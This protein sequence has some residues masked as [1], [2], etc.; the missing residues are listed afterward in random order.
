MDFFFSQKGIG[1]L[2]MLLVVFYGVMLIASVH[3]VNGIVSYFKDR[4]DQPI[5][6]FV[7]KVEQVQEAS[8]SA[9]IEPTPE[10]TVEPQKQPEVLAATTI[11]GSFDVGVIGKI[12]EYRVA[13]GLNT[14]NATPKLNQTAQ[15]RINYLIDT[16]TWSHANFGKCFVANGVRKHY[17]ENLARQWDNSDQAVQAWKQSP[18]HNANLLNPNWKYVGVIS[19]RG[20]TV[21]TFSTRP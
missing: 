10:P 3:V 21:A 12:N 13:N 18:S 17:G 14:L 16:G 8:P 4:K 7:V 6:E 9:S 19:D 11:T 2:A 15:C 20:Y 5:V 1:I